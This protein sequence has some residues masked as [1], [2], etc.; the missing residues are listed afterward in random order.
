[1]GTKRSLTQVKA[2]KL[3]EGSTLG[4]GKYEGAK[5]KKTKFGDRLLHRLSGVDKFPKGAKLSDGTE[6][7]GKAPE[8][9]I[10]EFWGS[11]LIDEPGVMDEY[12]GKRIAITCTSAGGGGNP[13]TFDIESM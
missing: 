2:I 10:V 3:A 12:K 5:H 13:R 7:G 9:G 11:A 1:M 4:P 8:G 6:V